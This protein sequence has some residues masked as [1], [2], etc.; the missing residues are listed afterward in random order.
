M[1]YNQAQSF[2]NSFSRSGKKV[3][4]LS[5]IS[6][7]LE[8]VGNPQDKL[9]FIHIAGTNGKGSTLEYISDILQKSG[10]RT[11]KFTSPFITHYADRIRI[12]SDEIDEASI[13]EICG[14]VKSRIDSD[15]FSQFEITM[16]IAMLY[17]LREKCDI[18]VL[19]TGIGG[20]LDSTNVIKNPIVSVITSIS[21]DHTAI[22][23]NTVA[24]IAYQ[25]AG[26]IKKDCNAVLSVDNSNEARQVVREKAAEMNSTLTEVNMNDISVLETDICGNEFLYKGRK[27]TTSMGGIHQ[28]YNAATAIEV[29]GILKD[30]GY[31][32]SEETIF[33]SIAETRVRGRIQLIKGN[34]DVIVDGGHNLSGI[35]ALIAVLKKEK[36]PVYAAL[37]ISETK[38]YSEF[39]DNLSAIC[40]YI[41][42]VDGFSDNCVSAEVISDYLKEK[43]TADFMNYK[44][45]IEKAVMLAKEN[46]GVAVICGSLYLASAYLNNYT[47]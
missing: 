8:A 29:C 28:I 10:Y 5:R 11:G 6:R 7:L 22:L 46:N 4:D 2:I 16:A 33:S 17:F 20:L 39:A 24:E 37:G 38:D 26:I 32:I 47:E 13:A 14:F 40:E 35:D 44:D 43:C 19:E 36:R 23:G 15:E 34:P 42:C 1:D 31:N 25:K 9:C 45:G 21:L 30:N 41:C 27:Y 18:V 12:D 3:S